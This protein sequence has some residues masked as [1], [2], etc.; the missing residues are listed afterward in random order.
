MIRGLTDPGDHDLVNV[1]PKQ[2]GALI[3]WSTQRLQHG[4]SLIGI[5]HQHRP[6]LNF[7]SPDQLGS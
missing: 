7:A 2:V 5:G 6:A 1:S 4:V 3:G